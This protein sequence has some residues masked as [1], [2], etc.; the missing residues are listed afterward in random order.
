MV[1][2]A[3]ALPAISREPAAILSPDIVCAATDGRLGAGHDGEGAS[4]H[5][6]AIALPLGPAAFQTRRMFQGY[7]PIPGNPPAMSRP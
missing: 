3:A 1:P 5:V 4:R 7:E 2:S 6:Q